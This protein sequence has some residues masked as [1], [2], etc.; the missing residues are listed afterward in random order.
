[1]FRAVAVYLVK[2]LIKKL[3]E[4]TAVIY[5]MMTGKQCDMLNNTNEIIVY[6]QELSISIPLIAKVKIENGK[7]PIFTQKYALKNCILCL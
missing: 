4:A 7:K 1:M 2:A 3:N 5:E 6:T